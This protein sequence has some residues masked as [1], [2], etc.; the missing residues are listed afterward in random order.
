MLPKEWLTLPESKRLELME[1]YNVR[2]TRGVEVIGNTI[3]SDGIDAEDLLRIPLSELSVEG[4]E[5][6]I[7]HQLGT[8]SRDTDPQDTRTQSTPITDRTIAAQE[9]EVTVVAPIEEGEA[10]S[11]TVDK[12]A[13]APEPVVDVPQETIEKPNQ[14][15]KTA[16]DKSKSNKTE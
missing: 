6:P 4:T 1:K 7:V 10:T 16:N 8:E 12:D 13:V 11:I 15:K 2:K 5:S 14:I 9:K 3:V